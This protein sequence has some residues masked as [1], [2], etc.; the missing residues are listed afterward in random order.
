[1][2]YNFL[3][4]NPRLT[5]GFVALQRETADNFRLAM[6]AGFGNSAFARM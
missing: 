5:L 6:R 2:L 1:M 3:N 4:G